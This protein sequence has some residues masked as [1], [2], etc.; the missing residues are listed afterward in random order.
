MNEVNEEIEHQLQEKEEEIIEKT[1]NLSTG[2][3]KG[4]KKGNL[5]VLHKLKLEDTAP[6]EEV[7]QEYTCKLKKTKFS[8]QFYV[9]KEYI[10]FYSQVFGK[11]KRIIVPSKLVTEVVPRDDLCIYVNH[12]TQGGE[13]FELEFKSKENKE[14]AFSILASLLSEKKRLAATQGMSA[15]RNQARLASGRRGSY[16]A[17]D[18]SH[19]DS[20]LANAFEQFRVF[21]HFS[22]LLSPLFLF[23]ICS[24]SVLAF[25]KLHHILPLFNSLIQITECFRISLFPLPFNRCEVITNL[26]KKIVLWHQDK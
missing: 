9:L 6:E 20:L 5:A 11:K 26:L 10:G 12:L 13:P 16:F 21:F 18:N 25:L 19:W 7:L 14:A 2:S 17:I 22:S 3:Q 1:I 4:N 23:L 15:T 8:G 24:L